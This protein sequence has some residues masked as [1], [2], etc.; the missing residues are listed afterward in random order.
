MGAAIDPPPGHGPYVFKVHG[1]ICHL[2][3]EIEESRQYAQLYVIDSEE[4]NRTRMEN[5]GN[6]RLDISILRQADQFLR[7]KNPYAKA[8]K[9]LTEVE[10][11]E[12]QRALTMN[13]EP[14]RVSIWFFAEI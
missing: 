5:R 3:S 8:N 14:P 2:H 9:M 7:Q 13:E 1:A 10:A 6:S 12:N 4:A 11:E